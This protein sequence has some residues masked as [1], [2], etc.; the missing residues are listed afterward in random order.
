MIDPYSSTTI[1]GAF[2]ILFGIVIPVCGAIPKIRE[3]ISYRYLIVVVFL[4]CTVGVIVDFS[5]LDDATRGAVII[6]T[7][8]LSGIFIVLR[9]AEKALYNGWI[10]SQK[11]RLSFQKDGLK[12]AANIEPTETQANEPQKSH[13]E[14]E[15]DYDKYQ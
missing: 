4:A 6:G 8:I 11:I 9:S 1:L 10:G 15:P 14:P 5:H 2:L 13:S 7:A 3:V 12:A